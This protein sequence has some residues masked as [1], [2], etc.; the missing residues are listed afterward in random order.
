VPTTSPIQRS[1]GTRRDI[2]CIS[3]HY[4]DDAWF[5]KQHFMSRLAE[6]GHRVLYVQPSYSMVRRPYWPGLAHNRW[7]RPLV[8]QRSERLFLFSPPRLFPKYTHPWVSTINYRW[9]GF[10][11]A[12]EAERLDMRNPCLW[13]YPPEYAVALE[14][15]P[16]SRL[17][18]DLVDDLEA[19]LDNSAWSRATKRRI[20]RLLE[21]ADLTVVTSPT[22]ADDVAARARVC[23]LVG[24][25][26]DEQLFDN[27]PRPT[28]PELAAIPRPIA[29]FVGA[30]FGFIDYDLLY[31]TAAGMPQV[32]FVFVGP[33][34][35]E[36]R[37]GVERLRA[38]PNAYFLGAKPRAEIPAYVSGFDVCLAPFKTDGVARAV[39]PLK[40]YEYLA[41]GKPV[42]STPL[43]GVS[44]EEAGRWICFA[45]GADFPAALA[46]TLAAG[47][48]PEVNTARAQAAK[49]FSWSRQFAKLEPYLEPLLT[50]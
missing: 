43:E 4:W 11:I 16:H 41:C 49:A 17:V 39:S 37:R 6:R 26:Y 5:R 12:R 47:G 15:I 28:P 44:R 36:G 33:I 31:R 10:L 35:N 2:I 18:F 8:E 23:V 34:F 48:P 25:G 40:I 46:E 50:V 45:A 42:V 3:T 27:R 9:F 22:L 14:Q 38:L 32:S 21:R 20:A 7:L 19:Y 30:L 13:V 24:N 29:G 1:A